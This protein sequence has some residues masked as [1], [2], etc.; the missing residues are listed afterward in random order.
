MCNGSK[1]CKA[2]QVGSI[3]SIMKTRKSKKGTLGTVI[4]MGAGAAAATFGIDKVA[5]MVDAEQKFDRKLVHAG[6]A[7]AAFVGSGMVRKNPSVQVGMLTASAVMGLRAV[8]GFAGLNGLEG[9][10]GYQTYDK[11]LDVQRVAGGYEKSRMVPDA[12]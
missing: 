4:A 5:D 10:L 3:G 11:S 9:G 6:G 8:A 1:K 2:C 7:V 12:I